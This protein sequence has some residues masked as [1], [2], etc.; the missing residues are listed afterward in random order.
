MD[1]GRHCDE[2]DDI[3]RCNDDKIYFRPLDPGKRQCQAGPFLDTAPNETRSL[4]ADATRAL[5]RQKQG[6][7]NL[8][9]RS[10]GQTGPDSPN[11]PKL[12]PDKQAVDASGAS[13]APR[14]LRPLAAKATRW[15]G[16][17]PQTLLQVSGW[18]I[19]HYRR[20]PTPHH[21]PAPG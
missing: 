14:V 19:G 12:P 17:S 18:V 11:R 20:A 8:P 6:P 21:V 16:A 9:K 3:E 1:N 2:N 10:C 7:P 4:V 5:P 13:F 15:T